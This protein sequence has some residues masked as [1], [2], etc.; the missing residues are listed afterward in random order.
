MKEPR[1]KRSDHRW[2]RNY[3]IYLLLLRP[4]SGTA[5]RLVCAVKEPRYK[6]SDQHHWRRQQPRQ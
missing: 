6:R 3:D 4:A 2:T 5:Y 1:Y